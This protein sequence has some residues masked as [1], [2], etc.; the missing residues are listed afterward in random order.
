M[1]LRG[2]EDLD[3]MAMYVLEG[4]LKE[5]VKEILDPLGAEDLAVPFHVWLVAGQ[6]LHPLWAAVEMGEMGFSMEKIVVYV[7]VDDGFV[8]KTVML[9][10]DDTPSMTSEFKNIVLNPVLDD[11]LFDYTPPKDAEIKTVS[12][13]IMDLLMA[14]VGR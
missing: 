12:E 5:S 1:T 14:I 10:T 3:G 11:G 2:R 13:I 7:S 9:A 4:K 8:R 6:M